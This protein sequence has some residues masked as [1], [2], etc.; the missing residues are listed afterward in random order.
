MAV[1]KDDFVRKLFPEAARTSEVN[2]KK[3]ALI[4][5]SSKFRVRSTTILPRASAHSM[6]VPTPNLTT[7]W[8]CGF[9]HV[10]PHHTQFLHRCWPSLVY[11]TTP[12]S[13]KVLGGCIAL[14]FSTKNVVGDVSMWVDFRFG[15]RVQ[16][17]KLGAS[18]CTGIVEPFKHFF[19]ASAPP[20]LL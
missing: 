6:Q 19:C 18:N 4:S 10:T 14:G 12:N 3:L 7:L 5:V 8:S 1:S 15:Q 13:R 11:R 20:P 2:T 16:S 9:L 17:R